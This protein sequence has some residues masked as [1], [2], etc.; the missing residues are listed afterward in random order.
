MGTVLAEVA[1]VLEGLPPEVFGDTPAPVHWSELE[2]SGGLVAAARP[3]R[4]SRWLA[5]WH[6]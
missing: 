1:A 3:P 5:W 2:W 4:R 6:R